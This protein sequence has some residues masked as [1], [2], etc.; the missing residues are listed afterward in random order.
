VRPVRVGD[1]ELEVLRE[2]DV[3]RDQDG[4]KL[5][6]RPCVSRTRFDPSASTA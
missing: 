3:R 6:P 1:E 4:S 5:I 2:I